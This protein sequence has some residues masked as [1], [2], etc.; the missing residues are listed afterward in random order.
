MTLEHWLRLA[1][2]EETVEAPVAGT[3]KTLL[4]QR[5]WPA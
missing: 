5:S 2:V 3:R 1:E 4:G